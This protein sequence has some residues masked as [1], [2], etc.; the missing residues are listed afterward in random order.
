MYPALFLDRD[1]V[2]IENRA[3]Y[4]RSWADVEIYPQALDALTL[5][6]D[7]PYKIIMVTN[8][9]GVGQ[10]LFSL[11][12]AQQINEQLVGVIE[13]ANGR[14]DA[15]YL[16]PHAPWTGCPCRKPQ[17][18]M[19]LQAAQEHNLDLSHSIMIGDALTD[20]EAGLSAGVAQTI[21]LRTGRGEEQ[22]QLPEAGDY[23]PINLQKDLLTVVQLL[24]KGDR[25]F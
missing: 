12:A 13:A 16:C 19:L 14:I 11:E 9:S 23:T 1:G 15:T 18:G 21:L 24:T 10:G 20:L 5:L 3:N 2:I 17:P 25:P 22:N 8:Q 7:S 4:V 6:K